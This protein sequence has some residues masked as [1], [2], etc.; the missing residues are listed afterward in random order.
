M[1]QLKSDRRLR[2][3]C[4]VE[5]AGFDRAHGD[6][7]LLRDFIVVVAVQKHGERLSEIGFSSSMASMMSAWLI[8]VVTVSTR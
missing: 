8:T 3:S 4:G 7:H 2:A 1:N 6:V 5:N